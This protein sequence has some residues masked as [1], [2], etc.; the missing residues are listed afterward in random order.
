MQNPQ[1]APSP[2]HSRPLL[3]TIFAMCSMLGAMGMDLYLPSFH[4]I[5]QEFSVSKLEVQQSISVYM[6]ATACTTLF[7]GTISDT[8]GRRKVLLFSILG[9]GLT[10]VAISLSPS[11]TWL[12]GCRL[13]QGMMAG[14]G[15]VLT[16][17]MI[18]DL[19]KGPEAR[20]MMSL[21]ML[22]FGLG[23]AI[24]PILGGLLQ[25]H[26]GW[27]SG[28]YFLTIFSCILLAL[29]W[30]A[31]PE[32]LPVS[33]RTPL[34]INV[35]GKNYLQALR[36]RQ[37]VAMALGL[38]L[39]VGSNSLYIT[40]APEFIIN[41]L[42]LDATSYGWLFVPH[43]SGIMLGSATAGMLASKMSVATQS[44][45][46]YIGLLLA[47][48]L[49]V[50]YNLL[51]DSPSVPWAVIPITIYAFS[52]ALLMPIKS[53]EIINFFPKTKGLT[54]S[55]Q[56]FSQMFMFAMLAGMLVPLLYHSAKALALGHAVCTLL[57]MAIWYCSTLFQKRNTES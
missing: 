4:A 25:T 54:S 51:T 48:I 41:I 50:S 53:I 27:R 30:K 1:A 32:T 39:M 45:I 43:I 2:T 17:T 26:F 11:F 29:C 7:Y 40:S 37:F 31:L 36:N 16:R 44:K 52:S 20:R 6:L 33:A 57:G 49:N 21:V 8:F 46:A 14:A 5:S 38:G 42:H 35:L 28:F 15:M 47:T 9:Y 55:L 10:S 3:L 18:Q 34:K 24:A 23:P 13:I 56:S 12:V 22:C 19:Y